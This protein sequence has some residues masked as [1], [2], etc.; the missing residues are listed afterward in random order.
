MK[1][2]I[3]AAI[4]GEDLSPVVLRAALATVF[5][6]QATP[7]QIGA[8]LVALRMRGEG[9]DELAVAATVMREHCVGVKLAPMP[10]LLDTCGTGGD[11]R[12]TFNISTAA[13]LVIAACDV[14]VAKHG[15][16][17]ASS[18]VGSADVLEELGVR[19]DLSAEEVARCIE[20]LGIGFMF[21][22]AH[23][24]AMRHVA[25]VRA[26]LGVRTIFNLIGPLSNPAA[27]THQVVGVPSAQLLTPFADALARLGSRRVWVVHGH[28]GLDELALA[29]P[30]QVIE[31]DAGEVR[32]FS[33]QPEDFG[34][35]TQ[36][37][38]DARFVV[39]S[40]AQSAAV[41]RTVL[42][43]ER[44]AARDVVL[45]NA[46]AGLIVAGRAPSFVQA[47]QLAAEAIDSGAALGKLSTW[48]A[49]T[50]TGQG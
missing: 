1:T 35:R 41:I 38:A 48:A 37:D 42:Q 28:G 2:A 45:L 30:S 36:V 3:A 39:E 23:H 4:S 49:L 50:Q 31:V 11:G 40:S 7:A 8:L 17:G 5:E 20:E 46:A 44:G 15:N 18:K 43:G 26:E 29:G 47:A 14:P 19:I 27:A 9:A 32:H 25:Q 6:G 22:R 10:V 21:A 24:P 13:A 16:R 33:V 12:N 34:L